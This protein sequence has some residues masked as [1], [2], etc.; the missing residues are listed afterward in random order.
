MERGHF[1]CDIIMF[2]YNNYFDLKFTECS[3]TKKIKV[4]IR[5]S[6]HGNFKGRYMIFFSPRNRIQRPK[7]HTNAMVSLT[8]LELHFFGGAVLFVTTQIHFL[9]K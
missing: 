3:P 6:D 4:K 7:I 9:T 8:D 5:K 2:M 1:S